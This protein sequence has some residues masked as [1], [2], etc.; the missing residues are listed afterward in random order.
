[1]VYEKY[2]DQLA[3]SSPGGREGLAVWYQIMRE[4]PGEKKVAKSFELTEI[5]RQIMRAGIRET[6]PEADEETIQRI[7]VDRLLRLQGI[8]LDKLPRSGIQ[9]FVPPRLLDD[10]SLRT[11]SPRH[12]LERIA[13]CQIRTATPGMP[14]SDPECQSPVHFRS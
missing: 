12:G 8:S 4:M 5:T 13:S 7:F 3:A 10:G 2:E 14:P 6:H 11:D 9:T 1:M